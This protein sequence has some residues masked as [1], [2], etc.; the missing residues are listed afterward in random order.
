MA[1]TAGTK[2]AMIPVL[3]TLAFQEQETGHKIR[4]VPSTLEDDECCEENTAEIA[5]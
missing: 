3:V 2:T 1:G 5:V 4:E